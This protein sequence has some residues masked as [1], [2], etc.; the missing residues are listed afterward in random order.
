MARLYPK[1]YPGFEKEPG[2][3]FQTHISRTNKL[4]ENLA[5]TSADLSRKAARQAEA[6]SLRGIMLRFH[7]ADGFAFYLVVNSNPLT[8]QHIPFGDA[9]SVSAAHIRGLSRSDVIAQMGQQSS[10]N[11]AQD[12]RRSFILS[13]KK[14]DNIH[15]HYGFGQFVRYLVTRKTPT[16]ATIKPVALVGKWKDSEIG[17]R[18]RTGEVMMSYH[19]KEI[20]A[21][22]EIDA[23]LSM[24]HLSN[25]Y[26]AASY[27][28]AH[29]THDVDPR[30]LKPISLEVPELP[31]EEQEKAKL[32]KAVQQVSESLNVSVKDPRELLV[33]ARKVINEALGE[34][35]W[36]EQ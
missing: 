35:R 24:P 29:P 15:Y 8:V 12:E 16:S 11:A 2:E 9:Y 18:L 23:M 26:E 3:N 17:H 25:M 7:V 21:G 33:R 20:L 10:D 31:Q 1:P 14:G 22:K 36:Q 13:L 34:N 27:V 6:K 32:W 28:R 5:R 30:P 4:L 19:A